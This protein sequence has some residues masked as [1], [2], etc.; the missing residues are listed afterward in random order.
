MQTAAMTKTDWRIVGEETGSCN[1]AWGCP[2]QFNALPTHGRCEALVGLQIREGYFGETR[3][4]GVRFATIFSWPGPIHEGNGTR[5][6]VLDEQSTQEQRDALISMTSGTQGGTIF[7]IFAAV[8]PNV[9]EPVVAPISLE[10]DRERRQATLHIPDVG[11]FRIEPIKNPVTGEE[12]R[13]RIVIPDG[14]EYQEAEMGNTTYVRVHSDEKV[15]FEHENSYA[16]L[17]EFEWSNA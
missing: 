16:Q 2:C 15:A 17:N 12:H 7:E 3:L 9:L 1:C 10:S 11:E 8:C 4:D 6:L 13:A 14:F 5:Q